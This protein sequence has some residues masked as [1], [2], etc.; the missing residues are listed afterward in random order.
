MAEAS[1][2]DPTADREGRSREEEVLRARRASL[3]RLGDRAFAISLN[4]ALGVGEPTP[5]ATVRSSFV[6][7]P[8]DHRTDEAVSIAGRVV[9]WRDMGKLKFATLRDS[10]GDLQLV[11]DR[12]T[13]EEDL[14]DI[15]GAIGRVG[16]TRRGELSVFVDRWAM[17]TKSS[18]PLPEKWHGLRD[19]D[20][21]HRRRY[22]H[23]IA[24]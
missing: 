20:L 13:V 1:G 23:L 12:T 10:A 4:D 8:A 16:T 3:E 15:V 21:Q 22:L 24:D 11:F 14:G 6:D 5:T 9:L 19:P 2:G 7:L 18:R 17:L